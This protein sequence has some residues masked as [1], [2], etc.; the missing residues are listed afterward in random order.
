MNARDTQSLGETKVKKSRLARSLA[1]SE[2]E[3]NKRGKF[4]LKELAKQTLFMQVTDEEQQWRGREVNFGCEKG[5]CALK[6]Q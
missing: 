5:Q 4:T 2:R 3:Y 6:A 1:R